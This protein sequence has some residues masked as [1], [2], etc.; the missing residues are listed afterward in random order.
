MKDV[1][2]YSGVAQ[3]YSATRGERTYF[4]Q[5]PDPCQSKLDDYAVAHEMT[6]CIFYD[7]G[8][9]LL[10]LETAYCKNQ[11]AAEMAEAIQTM[12]HDILVQDYL[13]QRGYRLKRFFIREKDE[14]R[15]KL[16]A[17]GREPDQEFD[18]W[19]WRF[20]FASAVLDWHQIN[21]NS[22]PEYF[23]WYASRFPNI[24]REGREIAGFVL[25]SDGF[26]SPEKM[27]LL[28]SA[29]LKR[30]DLSGYFKSL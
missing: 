8:F 29:I 19:L 26:S 30:Y 21:P 12:L 20:N 9:P 10:S 25:G 13:G 15:E 27:T 4:I 11:R 22:E 14:E 3:G 16:S 23:T 28:L 5:I 18:V 24:A 17:L 7:Q 6:H 2:W 1:V